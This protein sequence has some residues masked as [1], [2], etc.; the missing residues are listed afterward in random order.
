MSREHFFLPGAFE[1]AEWCQRAKEGGGGLGQRILGGVNGMMDAL[2]SFP[3]GVYKELCLVRV[4]GYPFVW[5]DIIHIISKPFSENIQ[6]TSLDV[7]PNTK[8]TKKNMYPNCCRVR[9]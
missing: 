2:S 9:K 7:I 3:R 1:A 6:V 5:F 4:G 8:Q